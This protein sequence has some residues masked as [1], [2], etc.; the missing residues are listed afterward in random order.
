M[1][2]T[3]TLLIHWDHSDFMVHYCC[4]FSTGILSRLASI[5]FWR[6]TGLHWNIIEPFP[7]TF[8]HRSVDFKSCALTFLMIRT[9]YYT[10]LGMTCG[11]KHNTVNLR[12]AMTLSYRKRCGRLKSYHCYS[13]VLAIELSSCCFEGQVSD[14]N[15]TKECFTSRNADQLL[16]SLDRNPSGTVLTMIH[17]CH[18]RLYMFPYLNIYKGGIQRS[19]RPLRP[20]LQWLPSDLRWCYWSCGLSVHRHRTT[21][22]RRYG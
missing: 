1:P 14:D 22:C 10:L 17:M 7:R 19:H 12:F 8:S 2:S 11:V 18:P 13:L 20:T 16:N 21:W 4:Q 6:E 9:H 15:F 5:G 3:A